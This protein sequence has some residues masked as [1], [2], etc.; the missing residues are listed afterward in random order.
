MS[1]VRVRFAPSP[2]GYLHIGGVRTALFNWLWAR[3]TGGKFILR[4]EDTDQA[5]STPEST[6][7]ILDSLRWLGID[8]DEGP[9]VGGDFGP[10][11]QMERLAL[12]TEYAERLIA[13]GKAY[14]CTCTKETLD[15]QREALKAKDPKAQFKYP[16]TCRGRKE[17]PPG[18]PHVIRFVAP[19]EGEV[20][21]HD[22]VFGEIRTPNKE[23][24]D[25]VLIRTDGVPLYNFGAVVDDLTMKIT[26]VARGRDHMINTP[27]Q[28]LLYEALGAP[29]PE[30]AHLPM[31]LNQKGA[32]LAKR[33]GAVGVS[34]YQ[35]AGFTPMGLI[36]YLVRFGWSHGDQEIFSKEE[37]I[38]AFSWD[39]CSR[40]DGRFDPKKSL[41]L[42][43]AQLK[44][45]RLCPDAEYA[46]RLVPF[47][48][49]RGITTTEAAVLP[50]L[51]L[52][53]ERGQT[54]V[55][56]AEKL[57]TFLRD[58]VLWDDAA[59]QK[60]FGPTTAE[61]LENLQKSLAD[62]PFEEHALGKHFEE[63]LAAAGLT[64][65]DV[66]MPVRVALTG[67]AASPGLLHQVMAALGPA[68]TA[69][70]LAEAAAKA[71]ARTAS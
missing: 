49:A 64:I 59:V 4:I 26:L 46:L 47:L 15:A 45:P 10:Y 48:A 55:E 23:S 68:K 71:R 28:I 61:L 70:R 39:G 11:A 41:A 37:L 38:A 67:K 65:K 56:A 17:V 7:V 20:V 53:R 44:D 3:K 36:G 13:A 57:D 54:F 16:G 30:F 31:M 2:T 24:Q 29:V 33:D 58:E 35:N 42:N 62:A 32:K 34:E 40:S 12:Y 6:Q 8:W 69:S 9:E 19:T 63:F 66:G 21:Y 52:V 22:K 25:F 14:R 1:D 5:R 60:A 51:P 50:L 27:P 43:H 18:T